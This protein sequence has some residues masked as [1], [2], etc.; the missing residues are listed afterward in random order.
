M[1]CLDDPAEGVA[2]YRTDSLNR[3]RTYSVGVEKSMRPRKVSFTEDCRTIIS[4][5]D[6][7]TVYLFDRRT[8]Q[9]VDK[10]KADNERIQ[11]VAVSI[12]RHINSPGLTNV[13]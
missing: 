9:V 10:L 13:I 6:H 7:G 12:V 4:G 11:A 3:V 5:S 1:F 2:L 8:G